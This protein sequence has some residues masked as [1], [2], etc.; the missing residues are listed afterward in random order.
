M[1][2]PTL[3]CIVPNPS[4]DRTAEVDRV[5][6][7]AIHRPR[8]VVAVAGGKGLNVARAARALGAPVEAVVILG[9]HAGR[10]IDEQ[11]DRS[12]IA[13]DTAWVDGE[14]RT[15]LSVLDRSTGRMTEVYEPGVRVRATE[16]RA[17]ETLVARV[18]GGSAPGSIVALSGSFPPGAG[19]PAAARLVR[20]VR[21]ARR[22][23]LVDTSGAWLAAALA[24]R[25]DVVK[26]NAAEAGAVLGRAIE[27]ETDAL[28]AAIDL[29]G[30]GAAAVIVT[31]GRSGAVGWDGH[32]GWAL[33]APTV[34][35]SHAVGSGDA[36]LAG[37]AVGLLRDEPFSRQLRR[38]AGAAAASLLEAGPGNLR[39]A[40][41]QR[42]LR[43]SAV[44]RIR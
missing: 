28:G 24:A 27:T 21:R 20:A 33:D 16:W 41:A 4:I 13:H 29:A 23:V 30:A 37:L 7:G 43:E 42:L 11:L 15:C 12:G 8:T 38:A 35:G 26:V 9:G 22:R 40:S 2:A 19:G 6:L 10:W 25:P 3:V 17:F 44:R 18:A 1:P 32:A 34:A 31:R 14:T 39:R 36:F 5:E